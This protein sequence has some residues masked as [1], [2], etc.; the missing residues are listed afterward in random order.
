MIKN[1]SMQ[2]YRDDPALSN[3]ELQIFR[4]NPSNY[5]W[6][7]NA[8]QDPAKA[9]TSEIGTALHAL[10][11]EP[12]TYDDLIIV[13]DVKGRI[14]VAFQKLQLENPDNIEKKIVL[15]LEKNDAGIRKQSGTNRF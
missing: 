14:T 10:L 15:A 13:S 9:T 2:E 5:I 11:L 8:P 3:H 6:N 4:G 1:I 12:D 7:K